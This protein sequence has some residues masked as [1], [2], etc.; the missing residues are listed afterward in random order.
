MWSRIAASIAF[1]FTLTSLGISDSIALSG[2][3]IR[4]PTLRRLARINSRESA[5]QKNYF[6][7]T[8]PDSRESRLLSS[9]SRDSRPVLAAAAAAAAAATTTTTTTTTNHY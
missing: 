9:S 1:C 3:A 6:R 2:Q 4:T 8:W 7:S 5:Q